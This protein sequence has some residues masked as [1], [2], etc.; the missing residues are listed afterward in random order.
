M[1]AWVNPPIKKGAAWLCNNVVQLI[2]SNFG[3][4][5]EYDET[6]I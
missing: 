3:W 1:Q 2:S 4:T 5:W 6:T